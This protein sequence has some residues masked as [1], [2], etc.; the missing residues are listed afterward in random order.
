MSTKNL[1][2]LFKG[3]GITIMNAK[4]TFEERKNILIAPARKACRVKGQMYMLKN[5]RRIWSGTRWHCEHD[6]YRSLCIKCDGA[7]ICE[8]KQ[9][10]T[11]CV[12]CEGS[13]ICKHKTRRNQCV[14]CGG[15]SIC[16]HKIRRT[17]CVECKGSGICEHEIPRDRC[18]K[19]GG[20]GICKHKIRRDMCNSCDQHKHP[21]NWCKN[22]LSINVRG[23]SY[24][25]YCH[26]CYC[27][28]YSTDKIPKR[29]RM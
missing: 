24:Y 23:S 22:C 27:I 7:S 21:Q 6:K 15:S 13:S 14:K 2:R 18:V 11:G 19:C 17:R 16:E 4:S 20:S 5:E 8:H 25:P 12:K 9:S 28:L 3:I 10:R 1:S 26:R 29:Y